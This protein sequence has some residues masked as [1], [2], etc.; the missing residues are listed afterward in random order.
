VDYTLST[1]NLT[2]E[3]ERLRSYIACLTLTQVFEVFES[4]L[5]DIVA[6]ILFQNPSTVSEL[7]LNFPNSSF[8]EIRNELYK[9]QGNSNKGFIKV[10]RKLSP[11]FKQHEEH[12]IWG[13]NMSHWFE[14][15]AKVRHLVVHSRLTVSTDF[16]NYI[17]EYHR[18]KL[19]D[20]HFTISETPYGKKLVL[21]AYQANAIV[22]Y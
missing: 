19:F 4:F 3:V 7:N 8:D 18:L 12:N 10:L 20:L 16:E 2:H 1:C 11:F 6:E 15:I 17:Q 22:D 9:L 21:T 14:I 5:K 13:R